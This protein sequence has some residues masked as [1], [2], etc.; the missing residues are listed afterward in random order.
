MTLLN[1]VCD[2]LSKLRGSKCTSMQ[3]NLALLCTA[4]FSTLYKSNV[5]TKA[6]PLTTKSMPF[7]TTVKVFK[8]KQDYIMIETV[9]YP[10][11]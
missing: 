11:Y 3:S 1:L 4:P 10:V 7:L 2:S 9:N 6:T 8:Q 5:D